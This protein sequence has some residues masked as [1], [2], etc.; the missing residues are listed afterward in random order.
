VARTIDPRSIYYARLT[1]AELAERQRL[2]EP[3]PM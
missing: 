1:D 2:R 3:A